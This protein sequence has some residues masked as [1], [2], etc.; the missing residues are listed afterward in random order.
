[1]KTPQEWAKDLEASAIRASLGSG[2]RPWMV[3]EAVRAEFAKEAAAEF[4]KRFG[5]T[6]KN[7]AHN[8]A[9]LACCHAVE[10]LAVP[11]QLKESPENLNSPEPG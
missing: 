7:K 4:Q 9:V 3:V 6:T 2:D 5:V 10:A 8:T 11:V 1:M